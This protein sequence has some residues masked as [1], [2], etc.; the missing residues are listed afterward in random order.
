MKAFENIMSIG[1]CPFCH[2][3]GLNVFS[4]TENDNKFFEKFNDGDEV[5]C[6]RC[7]ARGKVITHFDVQSVVCE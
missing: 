5:H 6:S 3:W 2:A 1:E 7:L 4:D